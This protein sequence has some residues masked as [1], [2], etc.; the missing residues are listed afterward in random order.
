MDR[1]VALLVRGL[2]KRRSAS[3]K[4]LWASNYEDKSTHTLQQTFPTSTHHEGRSAQEY[5]LLASNKVLNPSGRS[6]RIAREKETE[7]DSGRLERERRMPAAKPL[8]A[9]A[10]AGSLVSGS[11]LA[12][13]Q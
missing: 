7:M 11:G 8:T 6:K 3:Q 5:L 12:I 4:E 9:R 13:S 2:L 1:L 10:A